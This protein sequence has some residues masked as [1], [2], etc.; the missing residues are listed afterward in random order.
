MA[1]PVN[2]EHLQRRKRFA[3]RMKAPIPRKLRTVQLAVWTLVLAG[4]LFG[5]LKG[6]GLRY[7]ISQRIWPQHPYVTGSRPGNGE[8]GVGPSQFVA[9][10][11]MLPHRASGVDAATLNNDSVKLYR[12]SDHQPVNARINTSGSGDVVV[13]QPID[14]LDL[15]TSYTFELN[16]Q[17][18]DGTGTSF[19]PY[20]ITFTTT[21]DAHYQT[22]PAAFQK[23]QLPTANGRFTSITIGSDHRLYAATFQSDIL[24]FPINTDGTL[25]PPTAIH[26][27]NDATHESRLVVGLKFDP[28][29]TADN[30]ILWT[31]HSP[32][33]IYDAPD[34]SS[35]LA[36]LSG[37]NLEHYQD[38]IVGLPRAMRDHITMQMDFGPD[39]A[40]YF[41]QGS[42]TGMGMPDRKWGYRPERLLSASILRLDVNRLSALPINV[43]TGDGGHYDPFAPDAPLTFFATGVRVAYKVI[44]HSNGHC[45]VA[46]NGSAAP[47]N[48]PGTPADFSSIR[49][50]DQ[51]Q[52]GPYTGPKV[53]PLTNVH[54]TQPDFFCKIEPGGYYGHPNP[55]RG[56]FVQN[57]G[58]PTAGVDPVECPEY[59]VGTLPDRN[60]RPPSFN[61]GANISPNGMIEYH[62]NAFGG[63]LDHKVL[64][65]RYSGGKDV[66]I[67]T[68]D[69]NGDVQSCD[70]GIDGLNRF[71]DPLD[72]AEDTTNGWLYIDELGGKTITLAKPITG[73]ISNRSLHQPGPAATTR[74]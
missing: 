59:P 64:I 35:K 39:G 14:P 55:Q 62:G 68:L 54:Q 12:T 45:Y 66:A 32:T 49:R 26:T 63:I 34:W 40:L 19:Q 56:E 4:A 3:R 31:T 27:I 5:L 33:T 53:P 69:K 43:Q 47:G 48:T 72:I 2:T 15:N 10:D 20:R 30:L 71:S 50:T 37:P 29:S 25:G 70:T 60:W 61:F 58:N 65:V 52:R 44:W 1:S 9:L 57:G 51:A 38:V 46:I 42:N 73:G 41:S 22:F 24:R 13:L 11:V 6:R 74:P 21:G 8:T 7:R 23:V 17:V 28:K 36:R 18:T 67:L 16:D